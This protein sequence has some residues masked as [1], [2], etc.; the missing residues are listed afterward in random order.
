MFDIGSFELLFIA[1]I[2]ILILGPDRLPVAARTIGRWVGKTRRAFHSVKSEI[3]RE[4]Q[5]DELKRQ[6][7]EQQQKMDEFMKARPLDEVTEETRKQIEATKA[8]F[9][10][11]MQKQHEE[12]AAEQKEEMS[13]CDNP[14][15]F[16]PLP[17][18]E[19]VQQS[20]APNE[21]TIHPASDDDIKKS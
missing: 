3:D 11:D 16:E 1:I 20:S 15:E 17:R 9:Y 4:L 10:R 5:L 13:G 12:L 6:L 7:Q 19:S 14:V 18:D 2:A 8:E 21:N